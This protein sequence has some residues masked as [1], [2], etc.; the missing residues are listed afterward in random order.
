MEKYADHFFDA[1]SAIEDRIHVSTLHGSLQLTENRLLRELNSYLDS[2]DP[3]QPQFIYFNVQ[4]GHFPYHHR[5]MASILTDKPIARSAIAAD[6]K[7]QLALTYWNA[8]A[9]ADRFIAQ[10]ISELKAR[11][12]YENA[13]VVVLS[14]HGE[15]LFDDNFLGH[16]H[17]LN[18]IQTHIPLL[19]NQPGIKVAEPVGQD[20]LRNIILGILSDAKPS[21]DTLGPEL[22]S[23][24]QYIGTIDEPIQIGLVQRDGDRIVL[25]FLNQK[26]FFSDTNRWFSQDE[27]LSKTQFK[28]KVTD[29]VTRWNE[30][31]HGSHPTN[32]SQLG[33]QQQ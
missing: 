29:L 20:E 6:A 9:N 30:L 18:D 2:S 15:S 10:A 3:R 17:A 14:D 33:N 31:R 24:F 22:K 32:I 26:V 11:G 12:L 23:V 28:N 13:L 16:G 19:F 27:L 4:A 1:R 8:V 5:E 21:P 7:E 25:D